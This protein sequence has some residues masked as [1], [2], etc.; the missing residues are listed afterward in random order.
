MKQIVI[1]TIVTTCLLAQVVFA[2]GHQITITG[3]VNAGTGSSS[4]VTDNNEYTFGT[5]SKVANKIFKSCKINDK[6]IVVA[7]VSEDDGITKVISA[8]KV[9]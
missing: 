8:K 5:D 9:R 7:V 1:L 4:I 3:T 2:A 6:C